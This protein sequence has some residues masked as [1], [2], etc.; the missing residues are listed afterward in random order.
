MGK[1]R[2]IFFDNHDSGN[3]SETDLESCDIYFKRSYCPS[4]LVDFGNELKKRVHPGGL[5]YPVFPNSIDWFAARRYLWCEASLEKKLLGLRAALDSRNYFGFTPRLRD[6][7]PMF[8]DS[9]RKQV[10]FMVTAHDPNATPGLP[11]EK[12]EERA[13]CNETRADCIRALRDEF[14]PAFKGGFVHNE[15]TKRQ[16]KDLLLDNPSDGKRGNYLRFVRDSAVCVATTGLHKSI[17]CKLGEY[18]ALGKAIV[19]ERLNYK[20][21]GNFSPGQNYF[22]F[23][24]P[25]ECVNSCVRLIENE[26]LRL[27]LQA[28]NCIYYAQFLR[29]DVMILRALLETFRV[30]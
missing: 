26:N 3:I 4:Y 18:V 29:P 16:F 13:E 2:V 21:P 17:G 14:G 7:Q 10:L 15:Y 9:E 19:S 20:V 6:L 22:E 24:S 27:K 8:H 28:N 11:T 30:S 1:S 12:R 25:N 5:N 23:A